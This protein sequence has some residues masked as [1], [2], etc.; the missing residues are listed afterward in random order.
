[1]RPEQVCI[2]EYVG[3]VEKVRDDTGRLWAYRLVCNRLR[4]RTLFKVDRLQVRFRGVICRFDIACG[5][6][7]A[8]RD[9]IITQ[10]RLRWRR[11]GDMGSSED[12]ST[13]Y[14]VEW[15]PGQRRPP[16]NLVV[17]NKGDHV[18]LELR[19]LNA[20]SVR[21]QGIRRVR[22]LLHIDRSLVQ[23]THRLV[24]CRD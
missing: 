22:D 21:R 16:R 3:K 7:P 1:M 23:Q 12:G 14:W 2:L 15:E 17:Y 11:R 4:K 20:D 8:L 13:I 10:A 24:G 6:R 19:F 18:R 5:H 9:T